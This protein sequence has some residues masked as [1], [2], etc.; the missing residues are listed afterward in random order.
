MPTGAL[1][2]FQ[3]VAADVSPGFCFL[4]TMRAVQKNAACRSGQIVPSKPP[5]AGTSFSEQAEAKSEHDQGNKQQRDDS[6][7]TDHLEFPFYFDRATSLIER[8]RVAINAGRRGS[9]IVTKSI[10]DLRSQ[11]LDRNAFASG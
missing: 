4:T 6:E 8:L 5:L 9:G 7:K 1:Q 10:P 2:V 3:T 11:Y